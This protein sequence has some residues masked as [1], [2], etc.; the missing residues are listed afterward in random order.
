MSVVDTARE[1]GTCCA[2]CGRTSPF[3]P[4][5]GKRFCSTACWDEHTALGVCPDTQDE[6]L[7]LDVHGNDVEPVST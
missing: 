3:C 6:P 2:G 5:C 4:D 1:T 7:N